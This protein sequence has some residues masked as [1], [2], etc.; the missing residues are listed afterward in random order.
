ME[1][2]E[3]IANF[4]FMNNIHF[5][6]KERQLKNHIL[7]LDILLK[8]S[9]GLFSNEIKSLVYKINELIKSKREF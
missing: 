5:S 1:K 9:S 2:K 8:K 7:K 6:R 4:E 3:R